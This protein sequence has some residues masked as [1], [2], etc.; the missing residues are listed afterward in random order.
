MSGKLTFL[1][2]SDIYGTH[3][4]CP[5]HEASPLACSIH[6]RYNG[7]PSPPN[8]EILEP[9]LQ[10]KSI[11]YLCA[12]LPRPCHPAPREG[13]WTGR[14]QEGGEVQGPPSEPPLCTRD[15]WCYGPSLTGTAK[16]HWV[17]DCSPEGEFNA[18]SVLGS[19]GTWLNYIFIFL[20]SFH[21]ISFHLIRW[22]WDT[23]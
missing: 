7:A 5:L 20:S 11:Y 18:T 6:H 23:K 22:S 16:G 1:P 15:P 12:L 9:P 3:W 17:Q 21:F 8:H 2:V 10:S 14:G 13:C 19:V 4:N